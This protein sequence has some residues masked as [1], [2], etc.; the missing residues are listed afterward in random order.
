MRNIFL[1]TF[2]LVNIVSMG[3]NSSY[4]HNNERHSLNV[5]PHYLYITVSSNLDD[6]MT[7]L[8]T[9][10]VDIITIDESFKCILI[11]TRSVDV[12]NRLW[13]WCM[14]DSR[15]ET[16]SP[17]YGD[18]ERN[19]LIT[20]DSR[21]AVR[22]KDGIPITEFNEILSKFGCHI[23]YRSDLDTMFFSYTQL[24]EMVHRL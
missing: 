10:G 18:I 1:F 7:T 23:Y 11:D 19:H 5:I 24:N 2:L 21:V 15:V 14:A 9:E 13:K 8:G 16:I 17:V 6:F 4:Y 20:C 12:Y 3:Q 22:L